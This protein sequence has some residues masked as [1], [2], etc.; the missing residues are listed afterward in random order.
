[1]IP[2]H[3]TPPPPARAFY[4]QTVPPKNDGIHFD[5]SGNRCTFCNSYSKSHFWISRTYKCIRIQREEYSWRGPLRKRELEYTTGK[6]QSLLQL[7]NIIIIRSYLLFFGALVG[8]LDPIG[9]RPN[10]GV[11]KPSSWMKVAWIDG[12]IDGWMGGWM[13]VNSGDGGGGS[14]TI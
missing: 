8:F 3:T 10:S 12:W 4:T 13:D 2:I 6:R 5:M 7:L 14:R 1:M 9:L 11:W